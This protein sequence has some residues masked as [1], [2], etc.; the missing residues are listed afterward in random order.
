MQSPAKALAALAM[1]LIALLAF[2]AGFGTNWLIVHHHLIPNDFGQENQDP[3]DSFGVFWETWHILEQDFYG[4]LPDEKLMTYAAIRGALVS[5]NDPYTT[6]V[7]PQPRELERHDLEGRFG[8]IGAWIEQQ[9]P[10]IFVLAIMHDRP[11]AQAGVQDGDVLVAVD[12]T[13][14]TPETTLQDVLTMVRGPIDTVVRISVHREGMDDLLV[15]AITRQ[16]L[17]IPSVSWRLLEESP[18]I[19]YVKINLFS[20]R[21]A[22]ELQEA[23]DKLLAQSA[24]QII[25]DLRDNGGGLLQT[26]IDVTSLFIKDGVVLY[27]QKRDDQEKF[28]PVQPQDTIVD[29][30]LIVLVN[31]GTASASEIVAGA[32]QDRGRG[33]LVGEKTFGK[34]SVQ[35]IYDL[36][37]GSSLHVTA[38]H[39]LTP[40]RHQIDGAGLLPDVEVVLKAEDR[41][42]GRDPQLE[43][44]VRL[45]QQLGT[46]SPTP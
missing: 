23:L 26:A 2:V 43:Q 7:E 29:V 39:W 6:F 44:A 46:H 19:G 4:D 32:I 16:E 22:S 45:L 30:P 17:E 12:N 9:G 3:P 38:A 8:G 42:Q 34:G 14:I 31:G 33:L 10:G 25:L 37:D 15:F 41:E 20:E 40:N 24:A 18:T 35:F 28:Y 13:S 1:L 36:S 21:T 5:L 11:A 27:E